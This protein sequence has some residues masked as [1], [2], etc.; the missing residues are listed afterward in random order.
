MTDKILANSPSSWPVEP[1]LEC[2]GRST[3]LVFPRWSWEMSYCLT[4]LCFVFYFQMGGGKP[5]NQ[6][7]PSARPSASL[8]WVY[9]PGHLR[10]L[11]IRA[12]QMPAGWILESKNK[13]SFSEK[14][15]TSENSH[16]CFRPRGRRIQMT[17]CRRIDWSV[18]TWR[19]LFHLSE[20]S[21]ILFQQRKLICIKNAG[22]R[23]LGL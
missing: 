7:C 2:S 4:V 20:W 14:D 19:W 15:W 9:R 17:V 23:N 18:K 21:K 1:V 6:M 12:F 13:H 10:W 11:G 3:H 8:A 5:Q 16:S 22:F